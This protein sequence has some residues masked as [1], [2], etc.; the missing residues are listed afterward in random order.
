MLEENPLTNE[1]QTSSLKQ[2]LNE[3]KTKK[4][5]KI[6]LIFLLLI[7]LLLLLTGGIFL[8]LNNKEDNNSTNTNQPEEEKTCEYN[9]KTYEDGEEFEATDGCNTCTC[10]KG[11]VS[12]TEKVC[13]EANNT[14]GDEYEDWVNFQS[15]T[16]KLSYK[17][18]K[19]DS[20]EGI[21]YNFETEVDNLLY[22]WFALN[23]DIV[24]IYKSNDYQSMNFKATDE[25]YLGYFKGRYFGF[26]CGA[27]CANESIISITCA[28]DTRDLEAVW[29]D[30][31]SGIN[32]CKGSEGNEAY[33]SSCRSIN[34]S[35]KISK[36]GQ[37]VY[38]IK[39][40][41]ILDIPQ[42]TFY[43]LVANEQRI[44]ISTYGETEHK[45]IIDKVMDSFEF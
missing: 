9:G 30:M 25:L 44:L 5:N 43:L 33:Y 34:S 10:E 35:E 20:Y 18:P 7:L 27:G 13:D 32:Y 14:L 28:N 23:R 12:C 29:T 45:E 6:I 2:S 37:E 31:Q 19:Q 24:E 15:E 40:N 38:E 3:P 17:L 36:W 39:T 26:G 4:N 42:S 11:D 8:L 16:C 21:P 22:E 1:E 41:E